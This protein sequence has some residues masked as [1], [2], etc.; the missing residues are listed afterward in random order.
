MLQHRTLSLAAPG[1]QEPHHGLDGQLDR[2]LGE[3]R[4][5]HEP[6]GLLSIVIDR[7]AGADGVPSIAH[8]DAVMVEVGQ[9]LRSRLRATDQ[10]MWQ[11]EREFVVTLPATQL[12]GVQAVQQRLTQHLGGAYRIEQALLIVSLRVGSACYPTAGATAGQ[13][14]A[15]AVAA[16]SSSLRNSRR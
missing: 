10:V 7:I 4:R 9:R 13:L 15:A 1:G 3:C 8:Q 6:L 11:G 16:R 14:L 5:S 2:Q 12:D